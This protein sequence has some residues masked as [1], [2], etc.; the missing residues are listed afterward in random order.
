MQPLQVA[1][2]EHAI[3]LVITIT[4]GGL[5]ST[6]EK[7]SIINVDMAVILDSPTCVLVKIPFLFSSSS[8]FAR[9]FKKEPG[10]HIALCLDNSPP[11]KSPLHIFEPLASS[12]D[13]MPVLS[14]FL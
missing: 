9:S 8:C 2:H 7:I 5:S 3:G 10:C 13:F 6:H 14:K 11:S 4:L 12:Y 1:F